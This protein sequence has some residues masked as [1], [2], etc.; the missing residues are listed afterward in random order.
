[1]AAAAGHG[2][3]T[4]TA[5]GEAAVGRRVEVLVGG[6]RRARWAAAEVMEWEEVSL[7]HR[8][9]LADGTSQWVRLSL[10][11]ET[12]LIVSAPRTPLLH[13]VP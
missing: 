11:I 3:A 8:L 5:A 9:E 13:V 4:L 6:E 7:L 12:D 10:R 2:G 1:M